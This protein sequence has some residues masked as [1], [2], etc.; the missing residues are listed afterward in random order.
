MDEKGAQ[1]QTRL[2]TSTDRK[3]SSAVANLNN[4]GY[5]L[6]IEHVPSSTDTSK[7]FVTFPAFLDNFSDAYN[8]EWNSEQV[9][10]RMDPIATFR[11]TRRA[12]SVS[13]RIPAN[14]PEEAA[15]NLDKVNLLLRFLY[16]LYEDRQGASTINMGPLLRVKFANLIQDANTGGPLLGYVNG[17][18][19]DPL[20]EDGV[21]PYGDNGPLKTGSTEILPKTI[22]LNFE[23]VVLHELGWRKG[24]GD[25][26]YFRGGEEGFPYQ[27]KTNSPYNTKI[28]GSQNIAPVQRF[29]LT[30][31]EIKKRAQQWTER[32]A[33]LKSAAVT[34]SNVM[35]KGAVVAGVEYA[36]NNQAA[37]ANAAKQVG[38]LLSSVTSAVSAEATAQGYS[39]VGA[40][41]AGARANNSGGTQ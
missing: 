23:M 4:A 6:Y 41:V 11:H 14:S 17:F 1:G 39:S 24:T 40:A 29:A 38:N 16:P 36:V 33:K 19:M 10:G 21:M 5:Q 7:N 15:E 9:F 22:R 34:A 13:W 18:T 8:S 20:L 30:D 25:K 12:I 32:F 28:E 2:M 3:Y 31:T 37:I 35:S 27:T 26:Y